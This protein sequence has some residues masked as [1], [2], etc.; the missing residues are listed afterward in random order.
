[1]RSNYMQLYG[2]H[3]YDYFGVERNTSARVGIV[4]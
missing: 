2:R 4:Y 1:M 3:E